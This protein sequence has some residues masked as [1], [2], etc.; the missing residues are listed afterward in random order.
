MWWR[1]KGMQTSL[2]YFHYDGSQPLEE[3]VVDTNHKLKA[4]LSSFSHAQ[5]CIMYDDIHSKISWSE[6]ISAVDKLESPPSSIYG[7]SAYTPLM[8]K[9]YAKLQ[10]HDRRIVVE[11][12]REFLTETNSTYRHE[13]KFLLRYE[14]KEGKQ[15]S[16]PALVAAS[17]LYRLGYFEGD[18]IA[19][20]WGDAPSSHNDQIIT[21]LPSRYL[22]VEANAQ[23]IINVLAPELLNKIQWYFY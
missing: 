8:E 20:L 10:T 5:A 17:Y 16:C 22:Q 19:P 23:S 3:L 21:L 11:G 1:G 4:V 14:S 12:E 2:E 9:L 13:K 6:F 7:E 15:F 18:V